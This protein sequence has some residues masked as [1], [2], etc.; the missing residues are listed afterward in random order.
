[1]GA[2]LKM[3]PRRGDS[4][5]MKFLN[6]HHWCSFL[7][8]AM[9]AYAI[10]DKPSSCRPPRQHPLTVRLGAIDEPEQVRPDGRA[11][12][13]DSRNSFWNQHFALTIEATEE[14]RDRRVTGRCEYGHEEPSVA[15]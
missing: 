9:A 3:I 10:P 15:G 6:T 2:R 7:L 12:R 13:A 4:S 11:D 5:P 1:M 14:K 8:I